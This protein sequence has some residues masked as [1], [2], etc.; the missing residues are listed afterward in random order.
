MAIYVMRVADRS[1][2]AGKTICIE[3]D[4]DTP[5]ALYLSRAEARNVAKS[6]V[7]A[8]DAEELDHKAEME[9]RTVVRS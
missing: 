6:L 8:A 9:G 3:I 5:L 2:R 4:S 1:W 7:E